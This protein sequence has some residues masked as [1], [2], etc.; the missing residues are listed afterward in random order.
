M[1]ELLSL[2][3][4]QSYWYMRNKSLDFRDRYM[5]CV[6]KEL[7]RFATL[8]TISPLFKSIKECV[9]WGFQIWKWILNFTPGHA[10]G[11]YTA[12]SCTWIFE[13]VA[14]M[15][16]F[17]SFTYLWSLINLTVVWRWFLGTKK[18]IMQ[19]NLENMWVYVCNYHSRGNLS[20]AVSCLE[21]TKLT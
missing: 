18:Y 15:L 8:L 16:F 10:C 14:I 19:C 21:S 13:L 20:Y 11:K 12:M 1:K 4:Q 6:A 5:T 9:V 2:I 7:S 3:H 17:I